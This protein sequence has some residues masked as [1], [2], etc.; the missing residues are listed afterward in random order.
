M[1]IVMDGYNGTYQLLQGRRSPLTFLLQ[2][3]PAPS[4][5]SRV[6]EDCQGRT[7][8]PGLSG[9]YPSRPGR[10]GLSLHR[11][12]MIVMIHRLRGRIP[13][14]LVPWSPLFLSASL[15]A[16]EWP[17]LSGLFV[18]LPRSYRSSTP[19]PGPPLTST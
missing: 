16:G 3:S 1:S 8:G 19:G 12:D 17:T 15:Q 7:R 6:R 4:S 5:C 10:S 11:T 18:A 13:A 9:L 2:I 14:V